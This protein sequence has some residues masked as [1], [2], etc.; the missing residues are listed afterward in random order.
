IASETLTPLQAQKKFLAAYFS[1]RVSPM[2]S[3]TSPFAEE[4]SEAT[5]A[6]RC[7]A[8]SETRGWLAQGPKNSDNKDRKRFDTRPAKPDARRGREKIPDCPAAA[9]APV[10]GYNFRSLDRNRRRQRA[11]ANCNSV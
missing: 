10:A 9:F 6:L 7:A 5:T 4:T 8:R 3:G 2:L 1:L 11:G